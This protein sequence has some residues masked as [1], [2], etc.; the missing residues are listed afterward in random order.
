MTK[1]RVR[2]GVLVG[3]AMEALARN[4][5]R[6]GLTALGI[7]IGVA[8]VVAMQGIGEGSRGSIEESISSLGSNFLVVYP[9][10]RPRAARASSRASR[11]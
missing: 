8:C 10:S 2:V 7:T 3:V 11:R 9:G 4:R 6:S 1:R 5:L